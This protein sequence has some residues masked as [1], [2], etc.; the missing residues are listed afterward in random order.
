[1]A[2]V[3]SS[4]AIDAARETAADA[5]VYAYPLVL[6][7]VTRRMMTRSSD[8][9]TNRFTHMRAFPD[10]TFTDVVS[11]NADT[12]YSTAWLDLTSGPLMLRVPEVG[13]RYYLL[14]MCDAWTNVFAAP[15]HGPPAT[16][17]QYSP[18]SVPVPRRWTRC[19]RTSG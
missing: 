15:G 18:S 16:P 19:R 5:Y 8:A 17:P 6:M 7:E 3:V 1:V 12:L 4:T 9:Q 2:R 10:W 14:Q 13:S 11:P